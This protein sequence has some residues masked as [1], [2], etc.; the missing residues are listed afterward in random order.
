LFQ[1]GLDISEQ[2][3]GVTNEAVPVHYMPHF[4]FLLLY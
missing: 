2:R 4:Y 3:W 1:Y